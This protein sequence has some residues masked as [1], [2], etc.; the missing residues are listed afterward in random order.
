MRM[1]HLPCAVRRAGYGARSRDDREGPSID[2]QQ[3]RQ[4]WRPPRVARSLR[5]PP[6]L[7]PPARARPR[8]APA[9]RATP[10]RWPGRVVTGSLSGPA[11]TRAYALYVPTGYAGQ[12]VSLIVMLHGGTQDAGDF[13]AGTRMNALAERDTFLVV[14]P[15]QAVSANRQGY[16]NWFRPGDQAHGAGEPSLIAGIAQRVMDA[17]A[18]DPSRVYVAGFSAGGAMAAVMAETYPDLFAAAA[19]HSGVS[20]AAAH[21]IPSAVVAMGLGA[22]SPAHHAGGGIPLIVFHGD[23]DRVVDHA[24][25]DAL[26]AAGLGATTTA[27]STA[28]GQVTSG[29]AYTRVVHRD[30]AGVTRVEQWTVHGAGHGW[31]GGSAVASHTDPDGPDASAEIVRFFAG[32]ARDASAPTSRL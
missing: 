12:A 6:P 5:V 20:Y 24:N 30:A 32:H 21:D 2:Q 25:A 18:V 9:A 27:S 29:R 13:A 22:R 19:V 31:S 7:R 11:G 3:L 28:V 14:Y 15:E 10:P 26:V 17:Y 23:A 4:R 16:W 8:V 1:G